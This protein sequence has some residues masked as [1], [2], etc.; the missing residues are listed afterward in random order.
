MPS[1]FHTYDG[2]SEIVDHITV[3]SVREHREQ[4]LWDRLEEL[5]EKK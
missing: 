1:R 4:V 3:E 2:V 5:I